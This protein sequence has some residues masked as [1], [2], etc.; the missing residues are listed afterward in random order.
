[1]S[2]SP[3][4]EEIEGVYDTFV[5][6]MNRLT[7]EPEVDDMMVDTTQGGKHKLDSS[8]PSVVQF[9]ADALLSSTNSFRR[10][11]HLYEAPSFMRFL[12]QHDIKDEA[13]NRQF[14]H[15][16]EK[17]FGKLPTV[18]FPGRNRES[19][20]L[21]MDQVRRLYEEF[22]DAP[23][24]RY[25]TKIGWTT[26]KSACLLVNRVR[27]FGVRK[28]RAIAPEAASAPKIE[29]PH[30]SK[31]SKFIG[32]PYMSSCC[33]QNFCASCS[34][35]GKA[36][37]CPGGCILLAQ[38]PFM[39]IRNTVLAD[40]LKTQFVDL[41]NE[42]VLPTTVNDWVTRLKGVS[43]AVPTEIK[44]EVALRVFNALHGWC[45]DTKKCTL[46]VPP[47]EVGDPV[48]AQGCAITNVSSRKQS[49][50]TPYFA[51]D[52]Y[53]VM[54]LQSQEVMVRVFVPCDCPLEQH[55]CNLHV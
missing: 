40:M 31:C 33:G 43:V 7:S 21:T 13:T 1:M 52:L 16:R 15:Y 50:G 24:S 14:V 36:T 35:Q 37:T 51:P 4:T 44:P 55:S 8:T 17:L 23:G 25:I 12:N 39:S 49:A 22:P 19:T 54:T 3:S 45:I 32:E 30:C 20:A 47:S 34:S 2:H 5:S 18:R 26:F 41:W 53:D 10:S 9:R 46:M 38:R 6:H 48:I 42:H 11:G 27:A 29:P 28:R